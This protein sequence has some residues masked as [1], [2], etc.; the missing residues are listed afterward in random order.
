MSKYP[1]TGNRNMEL[2]SRQN[3]ALVT[4]SSS[5]LKPW[6]WSRSDRSQEAPD[7]LKMHSFVRCK[8]SVF[9]DPSWQQ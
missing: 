3:R 9:L 8:V 6:S 4:F 7:K 5:R 2:F 1:G